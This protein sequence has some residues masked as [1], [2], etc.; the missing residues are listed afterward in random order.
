MIRAFVVV[1]LLGG[2]AAASLAAYAAITGLSAR[3]PPGPIEARVARFARAF[4]TPRELKQRANPVVPSPASLEEAMAHFADHCAACHG[5]DGSG[6][7]DMGRG[8][9]PRPPDMRGP[10][11]QQLTDGELFHVI[12][13]GVR[14]TGMPAFATGDAAG[15]EQSWKLV[16]FIRRLPALTEDEIAR[17][18]GM[19]PRSPEEVRRQMEEEAFLSGR[20]P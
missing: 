1:V 13:Q 3:V 15:E 6:E 12:E 7:T 17:M 18:E 20:E 11:T 19:N 5:N 2:G 8:L 16:H 14:F 9:F 10:I 4:A